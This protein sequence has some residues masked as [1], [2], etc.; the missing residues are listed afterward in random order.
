MAYQIDYAYVSH[1]GKVRANNEDNF[2]C[3]GRNIPWEN[4]GTG[5]IQCGSAVNGEF[6]VLAVFDGMGGESSGEMAAYVASEEL[7]CFRK[8]KK[9]ILRKEPESFAREA[10][11]SMN[12]AVCRYGEENR[13]YS[14]GTTLAMLAFGESSFCACNLGD[15]RIYSVTEGRFRQISTDHVLGRGRFGKAP[16]LQYLGIDEESMMLEP[17]VEP[18]EYQSG[19]RFLLCSDG[20]TDMLSDGEIADLMAREESVD[21][22]VEFI[23]ERALQKGGKDNIT[24]ILCEVGIKEKQSRFLGWLEKLK[25]VKGDT[26]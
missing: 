1:T 4:Q 17:S 16:L 9:K 10:C 21:R 3:C 19:M 5:G 22:T 6:P 23:L 15:S 11:S 24:I 26:L 12:Q 20:V 18:V 14:M 25:K 7:G 8:Q 13:I 2:W